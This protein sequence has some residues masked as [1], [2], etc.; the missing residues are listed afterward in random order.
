MNFNN[1]SISISNKKYSNI[2][3]ATIFILYFFAGLSIV[4]DFGLSVDEPFH[5]TNGVL[6]VFEYC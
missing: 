3:V 1:I 4:K 2:Y 6:L 5:R